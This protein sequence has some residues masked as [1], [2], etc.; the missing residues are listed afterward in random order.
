MW[1]QVPIRL[2]D[3]HSAND[4]TDQRSA[5]SSHSPNPFAGVVV[6]P[7]AFT[8]V[9]RGSAAVL[10]GP[11]T[12]A[13]HIASTAPTVPT[14]TVS[15]PAAL[16]GSNTTS[17][18]TH[19]GTRG[20]PGGTLRGNLAAAESLVPEFEHVS[21]L[22]HKVLQKFNFLFDTEIFSTAQERQIPRFIHARGGSFIDVIDTAT[23]MW[24]AV[25]VHVRCRMCVYVCRMCAYRLYSC[26]MCACRMGACKMS[27]C[28]IVPNVCVQNVRVSN[29][30]VPNVCV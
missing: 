30:C 10:P 6:I 22:Q 18:S 8:P 27:M 7:L 26:K 29:V 12:P 1:R 3:K 2:D 24:Y 19:G 28:R 11:P 5:D 23:F 9:D 4:A 14:P 17:S 21:R 15:A 25:R 20:V 13:T 16:V